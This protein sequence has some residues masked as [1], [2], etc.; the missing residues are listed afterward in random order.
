MPSVAAA[1]ALHLAMVRHPDMADHMQAG[2]V[3]ASPELSLLFHQIMEPRRS[4][5]GSDNP[6]TDLLYEAVFQHHPGRRRRLARRLRSFDADAVIAGFAE[7]A[8]L[9]DVSDGEDDDPTSSDLIQAAMAAGIPELQ[10]ACG[11]IC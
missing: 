1:A 7:V 10:D 2:L 4:R 3:D 9:I 5:S 11:A 8:D 6:A